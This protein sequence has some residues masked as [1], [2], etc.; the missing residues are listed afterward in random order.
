[1]DDIIKCKLIKKRYKLTKMRYMTK[2]LK[3]FKIL[4]IGMIVTLVSISACVERPIQP[5][6]I[7]TIGT[8][9][10]ISTTTDM[11]KISEVT[12]EI[13]G[14]AF[15]PSTITISRGTKVKW[16]QSDVAPHTI[17][18]IADDVLNSPFLSEG[19]I[20]SYTF[21]E[22]GTFEYYCKNHPTMKGTVIVK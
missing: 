21:S 4:A 9:P 14:F 2:R 7:P 22:G 15:N 3:I 18:S 17:T 20:Y 16:I 1:M 10:T 19:Q 13:K 5:S 11:T 6:P 8:T 12:I